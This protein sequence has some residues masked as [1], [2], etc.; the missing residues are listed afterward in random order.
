[1][2]SQDNNLLTAHWKKYD[3]VKVDPI[4]KELAKK[5]TIS[6]RRRT[7]NIQRQMWSI[8]DFAEELHDKVQDTKSGTIKL[9]ISLYDGKVII[10]DTA[11]YY[12]DRHPSNGDRIEVELVYGMFNLFIDYNNGKHEETILSCGSNEVNDEDIDYIYID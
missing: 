8:C 10:N 4:I 12:T 6:F 3:D 1:M 11:T 2:T 5:G 7:R 9:D